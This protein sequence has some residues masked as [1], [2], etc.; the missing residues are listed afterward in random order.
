MF[1]FLVFQMGQRH[2]GG[3]CFIAS[4]QFNKEALLELLSEAQQRYLLHPNSH[5]QEGVLTSDQLWLSCDDL[6]TTLG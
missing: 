6:I 5:C 3:Y 2:G 4:A 1:L